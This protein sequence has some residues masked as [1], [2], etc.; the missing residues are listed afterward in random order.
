MLY[1]FCGRK[2]T[3]VTAG[4]CSQWCPKHIPLSI[5]P[6]CGAAVINGRVTLTLSHFSGRWRQWPLSDHTKSYRR[7]TMGPGLYVR[8]MTISVPWLDIVLMIRKEKWLIIIIWV[9]FE[10]AIGICYLSK[11]FPG[12][13]IVSIA[14]FKL[15]LLQNDV[16]DVKAGYALGHG[17]LVTDRL[18]PQHGFGFSVAPISTCLR[19]DEVSQVSENTWVVSL[20]VY[21]SS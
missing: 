4:W 14:I 10:I 3:D 19:K 13:F 11:Q 21:T 2:H 15:S 6:Q 18:L 7:V 12:E 16:N 5:R 1:L 8:K 9:G 17:Y 20:R